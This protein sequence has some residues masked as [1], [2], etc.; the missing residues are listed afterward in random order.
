MYCKQLAISKI[1]NGIDFK[2]YKLCLK[3]ILSLPGGA[4]G[5]TNYSPA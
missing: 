3:A 1:G 4:Y 5:K 2:G